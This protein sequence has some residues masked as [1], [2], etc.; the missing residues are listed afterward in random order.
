MN[1]SYNYADFIGM[2]LAS[3]DEF[4]SSGYQRELQTVA[5]CSQETAAEKHIENMLFSHHKYHIYCE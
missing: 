4:E 2:S 3:E 5:V 1:N